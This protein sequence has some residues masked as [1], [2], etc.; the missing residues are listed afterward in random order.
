VSVR[1]VLRA[2]AMMVR[3]VWSSGPGVPSTL[4]PC[5]NC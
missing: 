5:P 2:S 1:A 4:R 3:Q